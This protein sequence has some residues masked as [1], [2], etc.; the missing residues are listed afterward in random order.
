MPLAWQRNSHG[1]Q[2][3]IRPNCRTSTLVLATAWVKS[4]PGFHLRAIRYSH[5]P[6][7]AFLASI[8]ALRA[9]ASLPKYNL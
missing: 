7:L 1:H 5:L 6:A 2:N 3:S 9:S 4:Q 8:G